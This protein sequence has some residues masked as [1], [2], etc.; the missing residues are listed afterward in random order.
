MQEVY[1]TALFDYVMFRA[2][3]KDGAYSDGMD[4]ANSYFNAFY[5]FV[6]KGE[7]GQSGVNPNVLLSPDNAVARGKKQ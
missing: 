7:E 6:T 1:Q 5:Q 4:L 3:Q 2:H